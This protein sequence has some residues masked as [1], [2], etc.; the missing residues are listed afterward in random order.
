M[1]KGVEIILERLKTNPEDFS[2]YLGAWGNLLSQALEGDF[3]TK[4][5]K[6][7]LNSTMIESKREKFTEKVVK[8]LLGDEMSAGGKS[9]VEAMLQN[10]TL[11]VGQTHVASSGNNIRTWGTNA[12]TVIQLGTETLDETILRKIKKK[13]GI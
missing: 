6:E 9:S 5:E 10:A 8:H 7:V 12:S 4:E 2:T 1:N 11:S 3:I 13:L